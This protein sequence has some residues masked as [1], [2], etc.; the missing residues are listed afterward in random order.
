[1]QDYFL[2]DRQTCYIKRSSHSFLVQAVKNKTKQRAKQT[3]ADFQPSSNHCDKGWSRII[4]LFFL[5]IISVPVL[6][7]FQKEQFTL[8]HFQ[9]RG[10][11]QM[12]TEWTTKMNERT[13]VQ[14][15]P[16]LR[17]LST[18]YCCPSPGSDFL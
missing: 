11:T 16:K 2:Q 4:I 13:K 18:A 3:D 8:L 9:T 7:C 15:Y 10:T 1:M 5:L 17:L 6:F 14:T 12:E